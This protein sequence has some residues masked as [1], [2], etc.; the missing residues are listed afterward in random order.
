MDM[1]NQITLDGCSSIPV[2]SYL[3][4]LGVLRLL[5]RRT[6]SVTGQA[7]D[8]NVRGWWEGMRFCLLTSLERE[9]ILNFFLH[10]YAPSPVIAPWSGG[11]GFY[12]KDLKAGIKHLETAEIHP[13]YKAYSDSVTIARGILQDLDLHEK[14]Q[15]ETKVRLVE[16]LRARLPM[17][18]LPWLDA[19]LVL[20]GEKLRFPPV[21]GT[22]GNDGRLEFT[23]N[24]M[25]RLFADKDGLF[26]ASSGAPRSYSAPL[27]ENSLFNAPAL[28]LADAKVGQ[29]SPGGAGGPNAGTGF[30]GASVVNSWDYVFMLEGASTFA[31]VASRRHQSNVQGMASFPFT[32]YA[33][34]AGWGGI[35][36][37]DEAEAR[38]EFWA[39]LWPRPARFAEIKALFG[40]GRVVAQG[41]TARDGI[42]FARAISTLGTSRGF[43]E[44][45]RYGYFKR[46]GKS[47]YAVAIGRRH[48]EPSPGAELISDLDRGGWLRNVRR[49]GRNSDQAASIR[50]S[51]KN[52]EETLFELLAPELSHSVVSSAMMAIGQ[53]GFRLSTVQPNKKNPVPAPPPLLSSQWVR[54]ADDRSPEFRIAAALAGLGICRQEIGADSDSQSLP[55][56]QEFPP[57]MAAHL[58][59]MTNSRGG[60]TQFEA[61]TFFRDQRLRTSRQ[62]AEGAH[63]PTAVWGHGG[64]ISNM[65]AVLE[66]R[67][68]EAPIRG[69]T[70]KPFS[71]AS[72]AQLCDL[73]AFLGGEFNDEHCN[74]LL[75]GLVWAMPARFLRSRDGESRIPFAYAALKPI[76]TTNQ[77]LIRLGVVP[78][79]TSIPIPPGLVAQLR[80]G[81][82]SLDGRVINRTVLNAF[83][84][85]RSSGIPSPF[86][87]I[88]SGPNAH[89]H[90]C[91]RFGVG[92]RPD[93]LAASLLIPIF[94]SGM[95]SLLRQAY[96]GVL[97]ETHQTTLS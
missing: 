69:L 57:P 55:R 51:V 24:L 78:P 42:D 96:P 36:C 11:S 20:S 88:R 60:G 40:E 53:L 28:H 56:V 70:E 45:Q 72:F 18:A 82:R 83:E 27:L 34:S 80:V 73:A 65:I 90:K 87:P 81:G 54:E 6:N 76:F 68:V 62:W 67:L 52:L 3:K 59:R 84:R 26:Q 91:G 63:S 41:R 39:P 7:A 4:A 43:S 19:C 9:D 46:A 86:D 23:N 12:P 49:F 66:R 48:A 25:Q 64:L 14:P 29:F 13:R 15:K 16:M 95:K 85:A 75:A 77:M 94:D 79:E 44:F 21:L 74:D 61:K 89:A 71:S 8:A 32:V 38:A 47:Y 30:G 35:E 22:G 58:T 10:H 1:A 93:R 17:S 33:S 37:A 92:I 5:S 50:H 31:S 2:A 97:T